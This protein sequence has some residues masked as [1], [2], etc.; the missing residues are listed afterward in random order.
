MHLNCV[1]TEFGQ[2]HT[3]VYPTCLC[4]YRTPLS[5]QGV[6]IPLSQRQSPLG[7][8]PHYRHSTVFFHCTI[9]RWSHLVFR[10]ATTQMHGKEI[11]KLWCFPIKVYIFLPLTLASQC[12]SLKAIHWGQFLGCLSRNG[13]F[14]SKHM[15]T[16]VS[17][18]L[19]GS[20]S[21]LAGRV[22]RLLALVV[23]HCSWSFPVSRGDLCSSL[24]DSTA[25][26][27]MSCCFI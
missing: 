9:S 27:Q 22:V 8:F 16:S 13:Q 6:P 5:S 23:T 24:S 12:S 20:S 4:R 25:W 7:F 26:F 11:Y 10:R 1:L 3:P 2:V 14:R 18:L 21:S 15:G 17:Q 19:Q